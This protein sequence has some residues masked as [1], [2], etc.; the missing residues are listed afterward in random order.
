MKIK[1]KNKNLK[2][3]LNEMEGSKQDMVVDD[4]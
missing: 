2:S 3:K 1:Y 4:K